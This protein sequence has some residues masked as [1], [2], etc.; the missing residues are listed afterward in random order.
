M[1]HH[2]EHISEAEL[3]ATVMQMF[4]AQGW[5]AAHFHDSRK[6]VRGHGGESKLVGDKDA[7]GFPDTVVT[8]PALEASTFF[9]ELKREGLWPEPD[10]ALWMEGLDIHRA[11]LIWPSDLDWL[12]LLSLQGR[13]GARMTCRCWWCSGR[14]AEYL[15]KHGDKIRARQ[16]QLHMTD[17]EKLKSVKLLL[18]E[19]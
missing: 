7:K 8:H 6:E 9:M 5:L 14:R 16:S 12:E 10:Q 18:G 1:S 11:F 2:F 15:K 4:R 19:E 3:Q 13:V 17:A